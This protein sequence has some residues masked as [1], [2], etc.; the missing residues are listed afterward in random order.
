MRFASGESR[1]HSRSRVRP[2]RIAGR[3]SSA[4]TAAARKP[5]GPAREYLSL[6]VLSVQSLCVRDIEG[7]GV[8][9][10]D[11]LARP[12][13]GLGAGGVMPEHRR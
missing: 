8:A 11:G 1:F 3:S 4:A 10:S 2:S 12:A 6:C 13:G 5:A 9:P 7:E